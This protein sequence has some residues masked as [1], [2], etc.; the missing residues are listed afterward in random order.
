MSI[1]KLHKP[2]TKVITIQKTKFKFLELSAKQYLDFLDSASTGDATKIAHYVAELISTN[3]VGEELTKEQ[4]LDTFSLEELTDIGVN[5]IEAFVG[6][7]QA[8]KPS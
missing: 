4:I 7:E 6:V 3:L 5:L 2:K 8:G 1:L